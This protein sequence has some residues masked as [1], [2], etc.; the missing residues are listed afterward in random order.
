VC[1]DSTV[2]NK[3][4]KVNQI[5]YQPWSAAKLGYLGG[6][7]GDAGALPLGFVATAYVHAVSSDALVASVPVRLRA[8]ENK[9][10][11]HPTY[12]EREMTG[13]SVYEFD[14]SGLTSTGSY[15]VRVPGMGRSH[16]FRIDAGVYRD[17]FT[18]VAHALY[19]QRCGIAVGPE[20]SAL[21]NHGMCHTQAMEMTTSSNADGFIKAGTGIGQSLTAIGGWHDA[22]DYD[23]RVYHIDPVRRILDTYMI[24]SNR[25]ADGDAPIPEAGNGVPDMLDEAWWGLRVWMEL[26]D[27]NDGGVYGGTERTYEGGMDEP[28]DDPDLDYYVFAKDMVNRA[29]QPLASEA[30]F[31]AAAAQMARL[32]LPYD[33]ARAQV[34][35]EHAHLAYNYAERK[36]TAAADMSAA[37]AEL[38]CVTGDDA[39]WQAFMDTGVRQSFSLA[40]GVMPGI[41]AEVRSACRS[42]W[43]TQAGDATT[44]VHGYNSYRCARPPYRPIR[45]GGGT[46]GHSTAHDLCKGHALSN[47][48]A[49]LTAMAHDANFVLGCNPLGRSWI[50]G[51]GALTP[52]KFL[53]RLWIIDGRGEI[54]AGFHIYGP[55]AKSNDGDLYGQHYQV[56]WTNL[57]PVTMTYPRMRT[58]T[59]SEWMAGMNEFTVS[60]TMVPS[61]CTYAYLDCVGRTPPPS[62]DTRP[63]GILILEPGRDTTIGRETA[64]V[65][66]RVDDTHGVSEVLIQGGVASGTLFYSRD[67]TL[68]EGTN[69][70]AVVA[71]D[72]SGLTS[73]ATWQ[74]VCTVPEPGAGIASLAAVL[75]FHGR[76]LRRGTT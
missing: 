9:T 38:Y 46:G 15:Y 35:F 3:N 44:A 12:I 2:L 76:C 8:A 56:F 18:N 67:V 61:Y 64:N 25:C 1:N 5:G 50:T 40:L 62:P 70:L 45:F 34:A 11:S 26:Q 72:T 36:G 21:F 42:Y 49:Y 32:L 68:H 74:V 47:N 71:R 6:Y 54:P 75:W 27:T 58:Y 57:Y 31:A 52:E 53:H 23:R 65:R 28:V 48:D 69:N 60:E 20:D 13:E 16:T 17:V 14:F 66:V 30:W 10:Y 29:G 22:G 4:I 63:P 33:A 37:A 7:L 51:V 73:T 24:L 41:D 59:A 55:F 19:L 43:L 39:Y